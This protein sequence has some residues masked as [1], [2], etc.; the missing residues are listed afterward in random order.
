MATNTGA[1]RGQ[2]KHHKVQKCHSAEGSTSG[3]IQRLD[4]S[5]YVLD[6]VKDTKMVT[7]HITLKPGKGQLIWDQSNRLASS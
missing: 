2:G 6:C 3:P 1:R 7:N 4:P 5:I